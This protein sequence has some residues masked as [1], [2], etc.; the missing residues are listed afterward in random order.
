M[1]VTLLEGEKLGKMLFPLGRVIGVWPWPRWPAKGLEL[2]LSV[3]AQAAI[4][5]P[6]QQGTLS[7]ERKNYVRRKRKLILVTRVAIR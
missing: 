5:P 6:N 4:T 7:S 2:L 1:A 3:F